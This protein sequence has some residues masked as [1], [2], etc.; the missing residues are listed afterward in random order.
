MKNTG[1]NLVYAYRTV[2]QQGFLPIFVAG[3]F[4]N[5]RLVHLCVAAGFRAIEYTLRCKD[6]QEMIPWIKKNYPEL[7]LMVGSTIDSDPI[8]N[9]LRQKL[10]SFLCLDDL[11]DLGVDGFVSMHAFK[12]RSFT[13]FAGS[14]LLIPAVYTVNEALVQFESGAHFLKMLGPDLT[15]VKQATSPPT[16]G[17]CPVMV[18]GGM[19]KNLIPTAVQAGSVLV[20][21]GFDLILKGNDMGTMTDEEI[22]KILKDYKRTVQTTITAKY[23]EL[24]K[25]LNLTNEEW[26]RRLP[27]QHPFLD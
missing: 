25:T 4:D 10:G 11:A 3:N 22:I 26:L 18:T 2:H 7:L 9:R 12:E 19:D 27:H 15:L 6:A 16:F 21:S 13:K 23:P 5:R 14:H 20:G 17:Y 8:V 24:D 1:N